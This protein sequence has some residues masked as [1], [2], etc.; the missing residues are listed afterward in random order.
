MLFPVSKVQMVIKLTI[1]DHN[2]S[3]YVG[4]YL[5]CLRCPVLAPIGLCFQNNHKFLA[6]LSL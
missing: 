5:D 2:I 4:A 3:L 6:M 1:Y